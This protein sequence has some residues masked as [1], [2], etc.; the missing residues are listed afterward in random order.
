MLRT[1]RSSSRDRYTRVTCRDFFSSKTA[2]KEVDT[3]GAKIEDAVRSEGE[4]S[5]K[6]VKR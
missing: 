5:E 4:E 6:D 2:S 1:R 3:G